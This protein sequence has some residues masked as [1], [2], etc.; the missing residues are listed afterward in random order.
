MSKYKYFKALREVKVVIY[1]N[2]AL[3]SFLCD[4][5]ITNVIDKLFG[6]D[7]DVHS[8]DLD[9]NSFVFENGDSTLFAKIDNDVTGHGV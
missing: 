4:S 3:N 8:L 7:F 1:K 2:M 5:D 6:S 9:E